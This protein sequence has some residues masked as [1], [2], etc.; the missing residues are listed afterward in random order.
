MKHI[1][2]IDGNKEKISWVIK[3]RETVKQSRKHAEIYYNKVTT[4]Q[5][6]YIA[7]HVGLFWGL[8]TFIIKN[9]DKIS[10]MIDLK[11]MYNV[12]TGNIKNNDF[13]IK[14]RINFINHLLKLRKLDLKYIFIDQKENLAKIT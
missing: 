7:L 2:Y 5:S 6:K 3:S 14:T 8:G 13:L 1:L 12:L 4:E 10:T 11:S 9:E